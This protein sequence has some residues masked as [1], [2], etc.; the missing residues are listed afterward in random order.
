MGRVHECQDDVAGD[1]MNN[2]QDGG[3]NYCQDGG[4]N[5]ESEMLTLE[6]EGADLTFQQENANSDKSAKN[7]R[8]LSEVYVN[9][10]DIQDNLELLLN[11]AAPGPDGVPTSILKK[12]KVPIARML[13][14]I[15]KS[16]VETGVIPQILKTAFITPVHKGGSMAEPA[17]CQFH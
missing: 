15:M 12:G 11:G 17:N 13:C 8:G 6:E 3:I 4:I 10:L 7:V 16:S 2:R 9:H 14:N 5:K 1:E